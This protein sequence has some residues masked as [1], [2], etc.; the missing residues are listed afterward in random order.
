LAP[1]IEFVPGPSAA[2]RS[3]CRRFGVTLATA[4][5]ATA[6]QVERG[7]DGRLQLRAPQALGSQVLRIEPDRGELLRRLRTA[8]ASQP[9]PRAIGLRAG[10]PRIIDATTGLG[11]DAM[12]LASLGCEV[13]AI[14]Q[15]PALALLLAD[16]VLATAFAARLHVVS[17]DARAVLASLP[18][19]RRPDVVYLDPMFT[20]IGKAQVKKDLQIL[21]A[22]VADDAA[23]TAELFATARRTA[24]QRV[25]VKRH[26]DLAPLGGSPSF[27]VAS[28]RI[29][30]DVY[31]TPQLPP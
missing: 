13:T 31:L 14:E 2:D 12:V 4:P 5:S 21:R 9:L 17:G 28:E 10:R 11:R 27:T 29:R 30:F 19:N 18:E 22:L 26:P 3:A 20:A 25:V 24:R 8:R 6:W 23:A 15:I 7:G 16:A 1:I